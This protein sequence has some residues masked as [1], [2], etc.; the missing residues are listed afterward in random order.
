[1]KKQVSLMTA[2]SL[3]FIIITYK[4]EHIKSWGYSSHKKVM[5][6][7]LFHAFDAISIISWK[8][9]SVAVSSNMKSKKLMWKQ[10]LTKISI[11]NLGF[12]QLNFT[13]L[14]SFFEENWLFF[15]I[16]EIEEQNIKAIKWKTSS[17][18]TTS[19]FKD[20]TLSSSANF[21]TKWWHS[22]LVRH[23]SWLCSSS[24]NH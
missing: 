11:L 8:S 5:F 4:Q 9:Q 16:L 13:T 1:M 22:F 7:K 3:S 17:S 20:F 12:I 19:C 2:F 6:D 23:P 18:I 24:H 21:N 14:F 10:S 15:C